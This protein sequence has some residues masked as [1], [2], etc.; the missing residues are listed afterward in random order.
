MDA[1]IDGAAVL[2][3]L[4]V[5][6]PEPVQAGRRTARPTMLT[7]EPRTAL[8]LLRR[9]CHFS[10]SPR[11]SPDLTLDAY[12]DAVARSDPH[13]LASDCARLPPTYV[14]G[15]DAGHL[16]RAGVHRDGRTARWG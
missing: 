8:M 13:R 15:A 3:G 10:S 11:H 1:G 6:E 7:T 5:P 4:S 12:V 14:L 2:V 9:S 16:V